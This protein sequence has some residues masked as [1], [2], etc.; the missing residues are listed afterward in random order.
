MQLEKRRTQNQKSIYCKI[1]N[2]IWP[3]NSIAWDKK[4]KE[5]QENC[6]KMCVEMCEQTDRHWRLCFFLL[7]LSLRLFWFFNFSVFQLM[8]S[9]FLFFWL[10][11]KC[12]FLLL[13]IGIYAFWFANEEVE[14]WGCYQSGAGYVVCNVVV[15]G[16]GRSIF[17]WG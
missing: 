14:A 4:I 6:K 2:L 13:F 17:N 8:F 12:E 7:F 11:D 16:G 10:T 9:P 5:N 15:E 1:R 3:R